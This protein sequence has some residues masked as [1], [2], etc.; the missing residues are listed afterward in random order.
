MIRNKAL[1]IYPTLS[2]SGAQF[3]ASRGWL[4]KFLNRNGFALRRR[5]TMAQKN[6]DLLTEKLVSFFDYVSKTVVSKRIS[7]K[8]IIAMDE[9]AVWFDMVSPSTIDVRGTKSVALKTTGHEKSHLTV[10]LAAKAD[11]TKLKPFVVFR[12]AIREVKAMQQEISRAV[13]ATS[14]NGWMNDDLTTAWLRSVV[15]KFSFRP[16]LLVWDAY[17]CHISTSTKQELR[18][19]NITTAVIPGGCTKYVQ[20][21][22]VM[23]NQ[24]FKASLHASYDE[25]LAGD[26]DKQYTSGGNLK[27]PS[28]RLL[29]DW[30]LVAWDKLDKDL[31]IKSFKVC[32]QSV[33][34]DGSEDD[35]ILCFREGQKLEL[36][37]DLC[38]QAGCPP[39]T[40]C[41]LGWGSKQPTEAGQWLLA[42]SFMGQPTDNTGKQRVEPLISVM[43]SPS[44]SD[45][46]GIQSRTIAQS[47]GHVG[48]PFARG[49][50]WN[51][52]PTQPS[53]HTSPV[54]GEYPSQG[55]GHGVLKPI[56]SAVAGVLA[57][58]PGPGHLPVGSWGR[59]EADCGG[60]LGQGQVCLPVALY[61]HHVRAGFP[62]VTKL[63]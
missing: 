56:L 59:V 13:V 22:D 62:M 4:E 17:R 44:R 36:Q 51:L 1:E 42:L 43:G 48:A 61:D 9:T 29:L 11:G 25:W 58:L 12:G 54:Q 5:T 14:A 10:V 28:R 45:I 55:L 63:H 23:W 27:A 7:E 34:P 49:N 60:A 52:A 16:R 37:L 3:R 19:Y 20:A 2:D 35:L 8:D 24:P 26:T 6:P 38:D 21:P 15:G 57:A 32:G 46:Q 30:V 50:P 33:K 47:K 40:V 18:P 31:I 53:H 39:P 41:F